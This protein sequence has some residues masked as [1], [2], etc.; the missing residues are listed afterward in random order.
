MTVCKCHERPLKDRVVTSRILDTHPEGTTWSRF[1][2]SASP[3]PA[4]IFIQEHNAWSEDHEHSKD[5]RPR[6]A[7]RGHDDV[8]RRSRRGGIC[9]VVGRGY[10]DSSGATCPAAPP[11]GYKDYTSYPPIAL[12]GS[13]EG[14]LYI[15]VDAFTDHGAPSGVYLEQ[16]REVFVGSLNGGARGL[17]TTTYKFESKWDPDIATGQ[18]VKGRCQHPIVAGSGT[19]GFAGATGRLDF[20]DVVSDG[21]ILYRGHIQLWATGSQRARDCSISDTVTRGL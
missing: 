18:Q 10:Y 19:G 15:K 3:R 6:R 13:L 20:K 2:R 12:T 16:G 4:P 9:P 7:R 11:D 8:R 17:F 14:C 21:S 5:H 1:A